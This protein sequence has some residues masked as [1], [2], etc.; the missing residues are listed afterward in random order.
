MPLN[1]ESVQLNYEN[2]GSDACPTASVSPLSLRLLRRDST[3]CAIAFELPIHF[4]FHDLHCTLKLFLALPKILNHA[5]KPK[6]RAFYIYR[7]TSREYYQI[8]SRPPSVATITRPMQA[9]MP[10]GPAI[11]YFDDE[12]EEEEAADSSKG[13]K[14]KALITGDSDEEVVNQLAPAPRLSSP[15][16][17]TIPKAKP[18]SPH[19]VKRVRLKVSNVK[20][21]TSFTGKA[22]DI[23][24]Q[25]PTTSV[26][27]S[28]AVTPTDLQSNSAEVI[29]PEATV[30][31][32]P[33]SADTDICPAATQVATSFDITPTAE[34]TPT[35]AAAALAI[36][37]KATPSPAPA[38]TT[39]VDTP[40][41]DKWKQVQ[42]SPVAIGP[43]AGSDSERTVSEEIIGWRYGP[44]PDQVALIDRVEDQKNMTRLIQLMSESFHLVLKVVKNSNAKDTL[45]SVLAPVVEEGENIRDELAILKAEMAKNKDSER[46]FKDSLRDI[47]GPDPAL[48]EAK[49]QAD[50]QIQEL[51]KSLEMYAQENRE[52]R[53][54]QFTESY[55][56]L[57]SESLEEIQ[58]AHKKYVDLQKKFEEPILD[59]LN[60]ATIGSNTSSFQMVVQLLQSAP[61]RLKNIILETASV[62]CVQ[63]LAMI[64]SLYPRIDLQPIT[65]GYADGTTAERAMELVSE[66]D[67]IAKI[68]SNDSLYPEEENN[69]ESNLVGSIQKQSYFM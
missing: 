15:P 20:P 57:K 56:K 10:V 55:R 63:T 62:A 39:I 61:S 30:S 53:L 25:S 68:M 19:P 64:K 69:D 34:T 60:S 28:P 47:A 65:T 31:L 59:A 33:Q 23:P 29:M 18:I 8:D 51:Q 24:P 36:V 1:P 66:V 6:C 13:R 4:C 3:L 49:K 11:N 21:N 35:A 14:H 45:L 43:T 22:D 44:N 9:P 2:Y 58:S 5:D 17:P 26:V 16:P 38:F 54:V 40:S 42:G 12:E 41:A 27:E 50:A 46:N 37:T 67:D 52:K 48:M 7:Q 32:P